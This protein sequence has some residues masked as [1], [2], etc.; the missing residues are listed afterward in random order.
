MMS[1]TCSSDFV[2]NT[3]G[4]SGS[5][6]SSSSS[7][8]IGV[9]SSSSHINNN[10]NNNATFNCTIVDQ[11]KKT[12]LRLE[13]DFI[14]S[15]NNISGIRDTNI[16]NYNNYNHISAVSNSGSGGSGSSG[17]GSNT[18]GTSPSA[19]S[20]LRHSPPMIVS[21]KL[22]HQQQQNNHPIHHTNH[23]SISDPSFSPPPSPHSHFI[24]I[25]SSSSS[26]NLSS[27]PSSSTTH[28][29]HH[30]QHHHP[31][32]NN[33]N[34]NNSQPIKLF[35]GN[36]TVGTGTI[37]NCHD[38]TITLGP[39]CDSIEIS[40]CSSLTII[41]ITKGIKIR[42]S[43]NITVYICTNQKPIIHSDCHDIKF[44]P[45]NT[46]YPTLEHQITQAKLNVNLASNLWS[47]PEIVKT[48]EPVPPS[49]L[50]GGVTSSLELGVSPTDTLSNIKT[51]NLNDHNNNTIFTLVEPEDFYPFTI[52][53]NLKGKTKSNP[54]ELPTKYSTCLNI[55]SNT[56]QSLH[57]QIQ[58]STNDQ[59]I[60]VHLLHLIESKFH[61][62][63]LESDNI[64]QINDLINMEHKASNSGFLQQQQQQQ[65]HQQQLQTNPTTCTSNNS[66]K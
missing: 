35:I 40:D 3:G 50:L 2:P 16:S 65:Q 64:R 30:Q 61:Q 25:S 26:S 44:A 54:C 49:S 24:P 20:I 55:K 15:D 63:L 34:N 45:Y 19:S 21:P 5:S 47:S 36:M 60:R 28:H 10:S 14:G 23:F 53:F 42:S 13:N 29:H 27:S 11:F 57:K 31:H 38:C 7:S 58:Q 37:T 59:K 17:S 66:N 9:S 4:G 39:C 52:P 46:H 41:G 51:L 43:S 62:W 8:N 56:I 33:N 12:I 1:D 6:S 18:S 32:N 22:I 48:L